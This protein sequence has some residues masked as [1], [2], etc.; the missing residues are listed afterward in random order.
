MF[1]VWWE[2]NIGLK[3]AVVWNMITPCG[4]CNNWCFGGTYRPH[5]QSQNIKS[6]ICIC[7]IFLYPDSVVYS[8][9]NT[10]I[11]ISFFSTFAQT[12]VKACCFLLNR[13]QVK[14]IKLVEIAFENVPQFNYLGR[15]VTN[16]NLIQE[17]IRRK[18]NSANA[19]CHSIRKILASRLL[20]KNVKTEMC[21]NILICLC[22]YMG[23]RLGLWH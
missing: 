2:L 6:F 13:K 16:K 10:P 22:F 3:N 21:S 12:K 8:S 4:S 1:S 9:D 14:T 17:G 23:M 15:A 19:W 11:Y 20:F 5:L 18:L 7:L